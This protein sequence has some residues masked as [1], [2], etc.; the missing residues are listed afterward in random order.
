MTKESSVNHIQ[1]IERLGPWDSKSGG[2][3]EVNLAL[4]RRA[5]ESFL[6]HSSAGFD[7]IPE[8]IRGLRIYTVSEIPQG[9][10]GGKEWHKIRTEYISAVAGSAI[11]E[12]IDLE[13]NEKEF[14]LDIIP[15][16]IFHTYQ[17]L[18]DRTAL[19]V[20]TNTLFIPGN[21]QTHDTFSIH[22]FEHQQNSGHP[23][24]LK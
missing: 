11:L 12:C 16:R 18:E 9:N 17:A 21:P 8:D 19:Q 7:D 6:S 15:P 2:K 20:V 10:V 14:V 22:E 13:G 1:Q 24:Y 5:L 23:P 4:S 3:L